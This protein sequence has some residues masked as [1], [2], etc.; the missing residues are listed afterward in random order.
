MAFVPDDA[1]LLAST[2]D[3]AYPSASRDGLELVY[4]CRDPG[5]YNLFTVS[6]ASTAVEFDFATQTRLDVL[7]STDDDQDA[8]LSPDRT[9]MVFDS[10]RPGS[11]GSYDL[12]F[13][14]RACLD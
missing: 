5:D 4:S 13:T 8:E 7:D 10:L 12:Y 1:V 14:N 6:R 3:C 2:G 11:L 9:Q